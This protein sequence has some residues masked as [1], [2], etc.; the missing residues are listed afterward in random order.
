MTERRIPQEPVALLLAGLLAPEPPATPALDGPGDRQPVQRPHLA[1][2]DA[3]IEA[4]LAV[5]DEPLP[6]PSLAAAVDRPVA[7]VRQ[8]VERLRDDYDGRGGGRRRGF[9][10]R[11]VAGGWRLYARPEH[12]ETIRALADA[13]APARLSQAALETLAVIAY[14]QPVTRGQVAAIRAVSVDSV[15]R[16]LVARGLVTEVGRSEETGA[17][18]YGTTGALLEALGIRS[19]GELPPL[20]P[21]LAGAEAAHAHAG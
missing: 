15:L 2:V 4:V 13:E 14:R 1:E 19:I 9:E 11:E 6:L 21:L 7:V 5:A 17:V 20:A 8:A 16:T 3:R 18:L 10:L 12:D